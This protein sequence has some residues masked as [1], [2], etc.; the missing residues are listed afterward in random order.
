MILNTSTKKMTIGDKVFDIPLLLVENRYF[1][2]L[3]DFSKVTG[4]SIMWDG[5]TRTVIY[6]KKGSSFIKPSVTITKVEYKV[7]RNSA[8]V[9]CVIKNTSG[10]TIP[11][12]KLVAVKDTVSGQL[13][14]FATE[15]YRNRDKEI[16]GSELIPVSF[17]VERGTY[18]IMIVGVYDRD[19]YLEGINSV[20]GDLP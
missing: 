13:L 18:D 12:N 4:D 10:E 2:P 3:R 11:K 5:D 9:K 8:E 19:S 20:V 15:I 6:V 14:T 16:A 7:A 17:L 1:I